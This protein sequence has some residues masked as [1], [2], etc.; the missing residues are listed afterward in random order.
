M[1]RIKSTL[2]VLLEHLLGIMLMVMVAVTFA[3][4]FCRYTLGF[5]LTWSHEVV[6]LI[7]IWTVWL[8][9]PIG[10][11]RASH[12]SVTFFFEHD[13]AVGK[14][15]LAWLH[16]ILGVLFFSLVFFLSFPVIEA[17]D[18]MDLLS[19]PVPIN[20]RYYA[21]TVG[22]LLAVFV[23]IVNLQQLFGEE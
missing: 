12:L 8:S 13:S 18:G 3:Q 17:F 1:H 4:V 23:L 2:I 7:L 6:I 10:L 20:A 9:I 15:R 14:F 16:T 21:S 11:D 19:I 5:S 22:S